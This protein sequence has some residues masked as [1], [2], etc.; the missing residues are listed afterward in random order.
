MEGK[1]IYGMC[2]FVAFAFLCVS[3]EIWGGIIEGK[4]GTHPDGHFVKGIVNWLTHKAI[5]ME[6]APSTVLRNKKITQTFI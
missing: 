6:P 4:Q 1:L 5:S 3:V 2:T